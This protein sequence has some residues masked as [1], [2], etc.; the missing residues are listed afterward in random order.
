MNEQIFILDKNK[1]LV[2]LNEKDF[3]NENQFQELLEKYPKLIPGSLINPEN[4][5]KWI[6]ISREIGVPD[7]E[8][9][10]NKWSLDH[11]FIDQDGIPTLIE[12]KRSSDTRIRREVVGQMLDYAANAVSYWSVNEIRAKFESFCDI[13]NF[14]PE[15]QIQELTRNDNIEKYWE[16]VDTNL[17]TGKIKMLFVA[18]K[19]PKELQRIIEFLNE[20]MTPA[21][22]L[23]VALKQFG[24][25]KIK[26]LV[27]RVIGQTSSAQIKKG[28]KEKWTEETIGINIGKMRYKKVF[29]ESEK[30]LEL[31]EKLN[32]IENLS[33]PENKIEGRPSFSIKLLEKQSEFDK[34]V[35]IYDWFLNEIEK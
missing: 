34:F 30:R 19:I 4:P 14:D 9:G 15:I 3:I 2:E 23:G 13:N 16:F 20:Q 26:T 6:V 24:N 10:S 22:V 17:K 25:D 27:P 29:N 33:I 18:D 35:S 5:R 12:V 21:E 1:P 28:R 32:T 11:L 8:L 7:E 31:L